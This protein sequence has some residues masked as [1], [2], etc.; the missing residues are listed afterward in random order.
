M[1]HHFFLSY[2]V[3]ANKPVVLE[4][5]N[6]HH[7]IN[8]LRLR[9]GEKIT[10]ADSEGKGYV[11]EI[12]SIT[13]KQL[14]A[15]VI[16]TL[17]NPEPPIKVVL[18]QGWPKGDKMDLIVEKCTE[19]GIDSVVVVSTERSIPR[20][21]PK[22]INRRRERWQQKALAAARQSRRHHI[23]IVKGPMNLSTALAGINPN[24]LLIVPWEKESSQS[25]KTILHNQ[26]KPLEIG[27]LVGPEGGLTTEEVELARSYGGK[28]V[29][30]G[31]R[32]LRTETAGIAC[33]SAIMYSWGD[34]G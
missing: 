10:V 12:K 24:C 25:L 31:P 16:S 9:E 21:N 8:V 27:I 17:P 30:L 6:A 1:A 23:P 26:N 28:V 7:A 33:L 13:K 14:L 20:P 4:E 18:Y 32:I 5:E 11:A 22:S 29:T 3:E 19:L 15:E 2:K 34:L